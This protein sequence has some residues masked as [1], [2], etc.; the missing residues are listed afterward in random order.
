M[1]ADPMD[2]VRSLAKLPSETEW[3]E[4]KESNG[5]YVRIAR[6]IS[7]LANSAA[8]HGRECAYR[9]W[10][11]NDATRELVGTSFDYLAAKAKGNQL[12][13]IWLKTMLSRNANYEFSQFNSE[14]KRFVLLTVRAASG[15]PVYFEN[16]AYIR[17]ASS[18][19]KLEPGSGKEAELW[20]RLQ[21][22]DFESLPAETD[23]L[24]ADVSEFI[25]IDSYFD[26]LDLRRPSD[27]ESAMIPLMEQNLLRRQDNGRLSITNLGALILGKNIERFPGLRK[28]QLRVVRFAG[29]GSFE[30]ID[31]RTFPEGYALS[32]PK[33]EDHLMTMIPSAEVSEGAFRFIRHSYPRKAVRELLSNAVIHQDLADASSGPKVELFED[34]IAF[35]NPGASLIPVERILNAQPKTRNNGLVGLLRQMGL[36][37][38]GGTGWDIVV[39]ACESVHL[40]SPR[41]E[42]DE[43]TGTC[44]TLFRGSAYERMTKKERA[45]ALYWHACLMYANGSSMSNQ[46]LRER[47]GL[48]DEKKNTLAI[49]RLIKDCREAGLVKEEDESAGPKNKRYIPSWA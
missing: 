18:S 43:Q 21:R 27:A 19:T 49:S 46:S 7:A 31:D 42:S 12:L 38:E 3:V 20:R 14:G 2:L 39:A 1:A 35:S 23:L 6:D 15:Q 9:V 22:A 17:E 13:G 25:S 33:A 32:L 44:V 40:G 28:R 16:I 4:F 47:F 5:D 48:G 30:I 11:V 36:C 34:R 29:K 24:A 41:I 45:D 37:E 10:G 8:F 26:L